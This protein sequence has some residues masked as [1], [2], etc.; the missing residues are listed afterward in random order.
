MRQ[1]RTL[2]ALTALLPL[3]AIAGWPSQAHALEPGV[4]APRFVLPG[5]DGEVDLQSLRGWWVYVDF[6]ASWCAPCRLS[7]P[8]MAALH[9]RHRDKGLVIVAISVDARRRDAER[10]LAEQPAPFTI[11]FDPQGVTPKAWAVQAMPTSVLVDRAGRVRF[12]HRGF[13]REDMRML[14]PRIAAELAAG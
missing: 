3:A 1:R 7:F 11:A 2:C 13:R 12:T 14:E 6:W 4:A 8:W 9:D 10:F 5:R